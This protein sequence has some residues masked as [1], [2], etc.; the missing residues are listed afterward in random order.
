MKAVVV[1]GAGVVG[2]A[3]AIRL[4]EAGYAVTVIDRDPD[5][6]RCSFGNAGGIAVT[7]VIPAAFPGVARHVP[8]WLLDPLGPLYLRLAHLPAMRRWLWVFLM[9]ANTSR[10]EAVA[11]SL[12]ALNGLATAD[13]KS[14]LADIGLSAD[15]VEKGA[16]SLYR[17]RSNFAADLGQ[18]ELKRKLGIAWR[19]LTP[20]E[21]SG[22][23]PALAGKFDVSVM[24]P[25][26]SHVLSPRRIVERLQATAAARSVQII[27]EEVVGF[28]HGNDL[29][30]ALKMSN[31]TKLRA[32]FVVVAAG[33]W[34]A[35]LARQLGDNVLLESERGYN[36]TLP[37]PGVSLSREIILA[38]QNYVMT[39]LEDGLRIGG[40]AEFSGL[41]APATFQRSD[42]LLKLGR[43]VFPQLNEA[44]AVKW[45]GNRPATPDSLPVIGRSTQA[46]NVIYAFGHGHLGLTQSAPTSTLVRQIITGETPSIS[47][48]PF[49]PDRFDRCVQLI[50]PKIFIRS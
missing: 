33:A 10:Y 25:Q 27:R 26:W 19:E 30:T 15:L 38:E 41:S 14:L 37:D 12:A 46:R 7:E 2:L 17:K 28:E 4:N 47:L 13:W 23:E 22:L 50:L 31:G 45:M 32:D 40:A 16:L 34:S 43:Q 49:R 35:R 42:A 1:I 6:D 29:A 8:G 9:S 21:L 5:G 11:H 44:G 39:P 20:N 48:D 36:T 18:W 24:L 3:S